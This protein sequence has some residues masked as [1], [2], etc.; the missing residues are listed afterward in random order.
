MTA[1]GYGL[2]YSLVGRHPVSRVAP[3]LLL[4]PVFSVIGGVTVLGES[5]TLQTALGGAIVIAGVGFILL[6]RGT[7]EAPRP[8]VET[9]PPD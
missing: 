2:W 7:G 5:L 1:L 3:F 9:P 4:L 6:E 8:A